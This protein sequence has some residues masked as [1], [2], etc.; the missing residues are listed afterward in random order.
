M[1]LSPRQLANRLGINELPAAQAAYR[2]VRGVSDFAFSAPYFARGYRFAESLPP[3]HGDP[4]VN[5][6]RT[7]GALESYAVAHTHGP[8]IYKWEH[9][10]DIYERHLSR[11]RGTDVHLV[12]VGVAGG[13]SLG[14][15]REYLGPGAQI[16]GI[17]IDPECRRFEAANTEIVIGDQASPE[18]WAEFLRGHPRINVVID[19]GGHLPDQQATTLECLLT[20][21][22]PGGVYVCEDIHG[23]FHPFHAFVDGLSRRLNTIAA[24][25]AVAQLNAL[26]SRVSS[27][28]RYPILTV[29]ELAATAPAPYECRRYGTEWPEDWAAA[30]RGR[31]TGRI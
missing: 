24:A 1:P 6:H 25:P 2:R 15:W 9:Y 18:F 5:G 12:E 14:M 11:F 31:T 16:S 29:V 21:I 8:G 28:H 4:T 22:E 27:V 23:P 10:F 13:G 3:R 26:Q 7:M 17:D 20:H 30:R 19:D